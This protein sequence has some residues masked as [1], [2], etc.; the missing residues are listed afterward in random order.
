[1]DE[2][3]DENMYTSPDGKDIDPV[4]YL[5]NT[6][7]SDSIGAIWYNMLGYFILDNVPGF[8]PDLVLDE[9]CSTM[10]R[11][12]AKHGIMMR[13]AYIKD[14]LAA[15]V[16]NSEFWYNSKYP[17]FLMDD[18]MRSA[19][20]EVLTSK[21]LIQGTLRLRAAPMLKHNAER[22]ELKLIWLEAVEVK[23]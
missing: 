9:S 17:G 19:F 21:R 3:K 11:E 23:D 2:Q 16:F 14:I 18:T 5:Y 6:W 10:E 7:A 20:R 4:A 1:M 15:D 13:S 8:F 22:I 12:D